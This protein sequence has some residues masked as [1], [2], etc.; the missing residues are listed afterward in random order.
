[1]TSYASTFDIENEA[2]HSRRRCRIG[3]VTPRYDDEVTDAE[4]DWLQMHV[5]ANFGPLPDDLVLVDGPAW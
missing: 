1:M 3:K 2:N 5:R 4:L